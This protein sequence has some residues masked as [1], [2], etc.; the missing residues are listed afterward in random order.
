MVKQGENSKTVVKF[1]GIYTNTLDDKGR[2]SIPAGL[3]E[4]LESPVLVLTKGLEHC[5]WVL[6]PDYWE[7]LSEKILN[8]RSLDMEEASLLHY[9]F[10]V[11]KQETGIDKNGRIAV[12]QS[13]RDYAGLSRECSIMGKGD[14]MELW[15]VEAYKEFEVLCEQGVR[16]AVKKLGSLW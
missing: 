8:P 12:P 7:K 2:I 10:I 4:R 14:Y 9:R 11:P 5:I 6:P 16:A 3:R 1:S 15:D 13:L